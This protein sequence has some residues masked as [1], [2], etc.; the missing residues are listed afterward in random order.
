MRGNMSMVKW[1]PIG[2]EQVDCY[3]LGEARQLRILTLKSVGPA[4]EK[5][6]RQLLPTL[7]L[8]IL[9]RAPK[10]PAPTAEIPQPGR[11]RLPVEHIWAPCHQ[12]VRVTTH[13]R[14]RIRK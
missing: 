7:G 8:R 6:L 14:S 5:R 4:S 12:S 2:T 9:R 11:K 1:P 3:P 13:H 10:A